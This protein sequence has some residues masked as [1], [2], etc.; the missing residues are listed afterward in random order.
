[1]IFL[2]E[3][4]KSLKPSCLFFEVKAGFVSFINTYLTQLMVLINADMHS[5]MNVEHIIKVL[6]ILCLII[7]VLLK[8]RVPFI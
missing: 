2:L 3:L 7:P 6:Y 8:S 4:K 5:A 1:M